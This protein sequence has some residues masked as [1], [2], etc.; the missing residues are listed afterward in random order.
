[1]EGQKEYTQVN[2]QKDDWMDEWKKRMKKG[3]KVGMGQ[4]RKMLGR[5]ERGRKEGI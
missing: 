5:G 1:M 2:K 4:R 3:R